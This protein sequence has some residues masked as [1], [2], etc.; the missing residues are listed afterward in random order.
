MD[1]DRE[2]VRLVDELMQAIGESA[3]SE[4]EDQVGE[5]SSRPS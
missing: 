1:E 2:Y 3:E 4:S 5:P